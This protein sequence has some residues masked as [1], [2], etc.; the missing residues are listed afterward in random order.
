MVPLLTMKCLAEERR[1]GTIETL[2][3]D[4]RVDHGR[5]ILGKYAAW[6]TLL[7]LVFWGSTAGFFYILRRVRRRGAP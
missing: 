3:D 7:Y 1:M 5:S 4:P 2:L 6:P